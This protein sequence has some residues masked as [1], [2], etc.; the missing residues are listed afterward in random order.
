MIDGGR[1][2]TMQKLRAVVSWSG[3]KDCCL[4]L[5]RSLD[6]FD[7]VGLIT[8]MIEDGSR[9]RSHGLRSN[10]LMRQA[11]SL[12]LQLFSEPST[13]ESY[14][15]AFERLLVRCK[16]LDVSHVIFGDM[17][18]DANKEW[19]EIQCSKRG[20]VAVEPL[21]SEASE[22][23]GR[24]FLDIGASAVIV[25]VRDEKLDASFLGQQYSAELIEQFI[26]MGIDPCVERG[27]FHTFVT[28]CPRFTDEIVIASQGVHHEGGCS[29][30]DLSLA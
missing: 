30:L 5:H 27:E 28:S 18:P 6:Q 12:G 9:S 26:S 19:A 13:W 4:A 17:Y 2:S 11:E 20:M 21:W 14:E 23:V 1:K 15:Q 29:A 24:E 3:G 25:T 8:T 16:A 7:I 10:L 22:K